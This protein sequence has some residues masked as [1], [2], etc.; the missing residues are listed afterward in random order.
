MEV[1]NALMGISTGSYQ[2]RRRCTST[3]CR[4]SSFPEGLSLEGVARVTKAKKK[5]RKGILGRRHR[6]RISRGCN[7]FGELQV[8]LLFN[9]QMTNDKLGQEVRRVNRELYTYMC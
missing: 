3:C 5:F 9:L 2:P 7:L 1:I 8:K 6:Q 4:Y